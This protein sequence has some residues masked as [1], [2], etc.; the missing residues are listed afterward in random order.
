MAMLL[1]GDAGGYIDPLTGEGISLGFACARAAVDCLVQEHPEAYEQRW[2]RLTRE[3]RIMTSALLWCA[4]WPAL[5]SRLVPL[6]A[7]LPR[8][9]SFAVNRLL[10]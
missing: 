10:P 4:Q 1:V 5:R 3:H 9:F 6:A 8:T 7:R 2:R